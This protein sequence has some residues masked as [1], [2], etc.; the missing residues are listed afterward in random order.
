MCDHHSLDTSVYLFSFLCF[1]SFGFMGSETGQPCLSIW[2]THHESSAVLLHGNSLFWWQLVAC[3]YG[4]DSPTCKDLMKPH[5]KLLLHNLLSVMMCLLFVCWNSFSEGWE[6]CSATAIYSYIKL[7][8]CL[9][10]WVCVCMHVHT[11]AHIC[12]IG[13]VLRLML[14]VCPNK[15]LKPIVLVFK[16]PLPWGHDIIA[17][18]RIPWASSKVLSSPPMLDRI[19]NSQFYSWG[20]VKYHLDIGLSC[21]RQCGWWWVPFSSSSAGRKGNR[22]TYYETGFL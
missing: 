7:S 5:I 3:W 11:Y 15:V 6:K 21:W 16:M 1:S 8:T 22:V 9:F 17:W 13:P 20:G 4:Y 18:H 2:P 10:H 12:A 14:E 19:T